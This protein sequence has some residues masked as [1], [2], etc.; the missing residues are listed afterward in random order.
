[1][2]YSKIKLS[3]RKN[4]IISIRDQTLPLLKPP[5]ITNFLTC[6]FLQFGIF[7]IAGGLALF[8]P[9]ILNK[10]ANAQNEDYSKSLKVC[11]VIS[12]KNYKLTNKSNVS[13]KY[14]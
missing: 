3:H 2:I 14:E 7:T 9:D 8:M 13:G 12:T 11:D 5:Q 6:C 1:M 10:L 4:M